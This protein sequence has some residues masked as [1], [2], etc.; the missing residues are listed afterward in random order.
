M[1]VFVTFQTGNLAPGAIQAGQP[2]QL[3]LGPVALADLDH[4]ALTVCDDGRDKGSEPVA[5]A[6]E[7]L[8]ENGA[9]VT[10]W[11]IDAEGL[12]ALEPYRGMCFSRALIHTGDVPA[13]DGPSVP[14]FPCLPAATVRGR[15]ARS[16]EFSSGTALACG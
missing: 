5:H 12:G 11:R 15:S 10:T 7:A 16:E 13:L 3:H 4:G 6:D 8:H 9:L 2:D 1:S 14:L